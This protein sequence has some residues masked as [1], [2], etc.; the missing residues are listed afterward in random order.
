M[1]R[2]H[3]FRTLLSAVLFVG[4]ATSATRADITL[5]SGSSMF[6][7][8]TDGSGDFL[9]RRGGFT[10]VLDHA[11]FYIWVSTDGTM[12]EL[13]GPSDNSG[14]VGFAPQINIPSIDPN[15][16]TT[17]AN[18]TLNAALVFTNFYE[19]AQGHAVLEYELRVSGSGIHSNPGALRTR[20]RLFSLFDYDGNGTEESFVDNDGN[21]VLKDVAMASGEGSASLQNLTTSFSKIGVFDTSSGS[22]TQTSYQTT[23]LTTT[24]SDMAG[25]HWQ[26]FVVPLDDPNTGPKDFTISLKGSISAIPEPGVMAGLLL[27]SMVALCY[28]PR[29]TIST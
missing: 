24:G 16:S 9:L 18:G 29:R 22:F 10:N 11:S 28:R 20:I 14:M 13:T 19:N 25:G 2:T 21:V 7:Y 5:T 27:L 23:P 12:R 4:L 6:N 15:S 1:L 17:V 26:A 8:D 3:L